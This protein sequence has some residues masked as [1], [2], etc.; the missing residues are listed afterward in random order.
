MKL[1]IT[2]SGALAEQTVKRLAT[3][4]ATATIHRLLP[5]GPI[6]NSPWPGYGKGD[7]QEARRIWEKKTEAK[8]VETRDALRSI[9][10]DRLPAV[11]EFECPVRGYPT[12][13]TA[14]ARYPAY[15]PAVA[16]G[17]VDAYVAAVWDII[18]E[19]A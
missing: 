6:I 16:K 11:P 7:W 19:A 15:R 17:L 18:G 3:D 5:A 13:E 14:T 2:L 9:I 4:Y 8:R 1:T 10:G 12:E